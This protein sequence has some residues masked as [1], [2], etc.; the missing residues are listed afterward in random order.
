ML[1][2]TSKVTHHGG[3]T[4]AFRLSADWFVRASSKTQS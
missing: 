4:Q 1:L 3:E 2:V